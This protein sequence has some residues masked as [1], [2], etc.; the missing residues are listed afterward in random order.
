LLVGSLP[1]AA[2]TGCL[3]KIKAASRVAFMVWRNG[4]RTFVA[5]LPGRTSQSYLIGALAAAPGRFLFEYV[6]IAQSN[7]HLS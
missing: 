4:V 1:R 2:I 6:S 7:F 3:P 5:E